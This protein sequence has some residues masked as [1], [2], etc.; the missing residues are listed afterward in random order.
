MTQTCGML[1]RIG[2]GLGLLALLAVEL[3]MIVVVACGFLLAFGLGAVPLFPP[4]VGLVRRMTELTR[5]LAGEWCGVEIRTPYRPRPPRAVP[6]VD[7]WYR[8]DRTLYKTP[9]VPEWNARWKWLVS[10]PATWRDL[11]WLALDPIV[12][13][14]LALPMLLLAPLGL[15]VYGRWASLLLAP[16][17][18]VQLT[19]QLQHLTQVRSNTMDSQAAEMRRIERDLHDGAQARLVALGMTLGAV[20]QLI[21]NDNPAA[22]KALVGKAREV[23]ADALTE[24]RRV[25]RGIHPPVLAERGLADAVR[26]MALDSPLR[27][28]V[29]VDLPHRPDS[30]VEAALYFAIS[31]LLSNAARHGG[32]EKA[33]V[34]ISHNG[35]DLTV[36]VADDGMG[37]ADPAKG[38]GLH[39]IEQRL[40]AFDGIIALSSPPG[41][42]TTV[43]MMVP[44]V[45]PEPLG[46]SLGRMPLWKSSIVVFGWSLGWLPLFPQGLVT[47]IFKIFEIPH[48]SWF[49]ALYLPEPWQW[50]A[51]IANILLGLAMYGAAI[52]LPLQHSHERWWREASPTRLWLDRC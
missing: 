5:R 49:Y 24:L 33:L 20:E 19:S 30:P 40:A 23:S 14:A 34:D 51:I 6:M 7:G 45:L 1:R 25:V 32:A 44:G 47:A 39:G 46:G 17:A 16:T 12:K 38:S 27:V 3:P 22:A 21:E 37:G 26:A 36:T 42:P 48:K 18:R 35:R 10:D 28:T 11:L 50:P 43:S 4:T 8:S 15:R 41:G 2:Q 52:Y 29:E 9:R 13:L 31:E